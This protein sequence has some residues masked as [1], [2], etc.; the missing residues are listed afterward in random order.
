MA[1][2]MLLYKCMILVPF[3]YMLLVF[4]T[5]RH[6]DVIETAVKIHVMKE[7]EI[8]N[9]KIDEFEF[10]DE[11]YSPLFEKDLIFVRSRNRLDVL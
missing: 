6:I 7:S 1:A 5:L 4:M 3:L 2:S 9:M 11:E 8:R 10:H